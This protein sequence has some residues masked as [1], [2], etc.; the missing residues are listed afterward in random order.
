M[1]LKCV[2]ANVQQLLTASCGSSSSCSTDRWFTLP[3]SAV[4]SAYL[5]ASRPAK[6]P[7]SVS[8]PG[9]LRKS[10]SISLARD[11]CTSLQYGEWKTRKPNS[12]R[13]KRFSEPSAN[14]KEK[15]HVHRAS[16]CRQP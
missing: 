4:S 15:V 3:N 12:S 13:L 16:L 11:F 1:E 10:F 8:G 6:S 14:R 2:K 9:W 7:E 5:K